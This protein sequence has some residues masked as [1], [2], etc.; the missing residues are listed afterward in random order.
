MRKTYDVDENVSD[1]KIVRFN[2]TTYHEVSEVSNLRKDE[3][4]S[5]FFVHTTDIRPSYT[6]KIFSFV[7][8]LSVS[9]LEK[10]NQSERM[11][12]IFLLSD[13]SK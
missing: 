11:T 13:W 9:V 6:V 3:L 1:F 2:N 8:L 7:Y 12:Q 4:I 5:I 10:L